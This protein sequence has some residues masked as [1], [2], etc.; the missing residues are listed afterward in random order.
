MS[1]ERLTDG[2]EPD[3]EA[4][5]S[6][7]RRFVLANAD[8]NA[9]VASCSGGRSERWD[10]LAVADP[11]SPIMF[12]NAAVLL[13][14]PAYIDLPDTLRRLMNFYPPERHFVLLSAWPTPDLGATGMELMGHPPFMMRPPGGMPPPLPRGFEIVPVTDR[15]TLDDFVNTLVEA[16]PLPGA[17]GTILG[18]VRVLRGPIRLFVGYADGR[19]VATSGARL[20]HGIVDV[21]WVSTL[22]S[23]RGRGIGAALT[24]AATLVG[25]AEPATLIASDDGQ[26]VYEAMGYIRLMRLTMWHRPP[27][28]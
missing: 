5:D 26:P 18:D 11:V 14:P 12:D 13:R 2:W 19:P 21:E 3:L 1:D 8:R 9:F 27:Q 10:D 25:P 17:Q 24:W 4:G 15:R 22:P 16:Y 23:H 28:V 6:L 20:G 7:L